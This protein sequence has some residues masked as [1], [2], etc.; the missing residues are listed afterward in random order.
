[1][2]ISI[3]ILVATVALTVFVTVRF[4]SM[5]PEEEETSQKYPTCDDV[6][7][8]LMNMNCTHYYLLPGPDGRAATTDDI[9][10]AEFCKTV[11]RNGI[12]TMDLKCLYQ[13]TRC[14]EVGECLNDN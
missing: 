6:Q 9:S 2:K 5:L 1:M 7:T 10:F 3:S 8:H 12:M 4:W 11:M 13:A 14:T